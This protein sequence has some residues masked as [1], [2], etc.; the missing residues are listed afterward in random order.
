MSASRSPISELRDPRVDDVKRRR[1][2]GWTDRLT[3]R[4]TDLDLGDIV[5]VTLEKELGDAGEQNL[6][7]PHCMMDE[8]QGA[9]RHGAP[10][11]AEG[12]V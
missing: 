8:T 7:H 9:T 11:T 10:G 12:V 1:E 6:S 2:R 4:G 5:I 3:V